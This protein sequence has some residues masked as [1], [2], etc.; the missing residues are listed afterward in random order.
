MNEILIYSDIGEVW[1]S[2]GITGAGIKEQLDAFPEDESVTVRINSLGGDVFEGFAIFNL[3]QQHKGDIE[4][5]I[6]GIAA[7]AA[8]I[9]AMAGTDIVMGEASMMMIHDPWTIAMGDADQLLKQADTLEKIKDSIVKTYVSQTGI[10][11]AEISALMK[12]ETWM[13]AEDAVERG[14]AH[15]I[16]GKGDVNNSVMDRP[17]VKKAPTRKETDPIVEVKAPEFRIA[18]RKR[19]STL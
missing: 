14:F 13:T 1:F 19:L 17:W 4:V 2:E 12:A 6:D 5:R 7:S 9:I 3:L 11:A 16:S 10:D 18:A 15:S 8:S